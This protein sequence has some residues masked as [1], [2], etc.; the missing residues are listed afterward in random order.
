[1]AKTKQVVVFKARES[2]ASKR[3]RE[4]AR[5]AGVV[6]DPKDRVSELRKA[7]NSVK[8][9]PSVFW[10][11]KKIKKATT[12]KRKPKKAKAAAGDKKPKKR[13]APKK[14]KKKAATEKKQ[15]NSTPAAATSSSSS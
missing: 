11:A 5:Q 9:D 2:E 7:L 8:Y 6:G 4:R 12:A 14:K 3:R 1:M 13:A 10:P 15:K